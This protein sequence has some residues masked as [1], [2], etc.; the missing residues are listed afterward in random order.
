MRPIKHALAACAA[1]LL[2]SPAAKTFT[3]GVAMSRSEHLFLVKV[4]DA[5]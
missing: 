2:A 5:I 1:L 4:R 3:V